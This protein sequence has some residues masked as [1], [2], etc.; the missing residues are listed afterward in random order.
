MKCTRHPAYDSILPLRHA[1]AFSATR[2]DE[3]LRLRARP[4]GAAAAPERSSGSWEDGLGAGGKAA[5]DALPWYWL[6]SSTAAQREPPSLL[7]KHHSQTE[8][9]RESRVDT[10][11]HNH[12]MQRGHCALGEQRYACFNMQ[13]QTNKYS[14]GYMYREASKHSLHSLTLLLH[15]QLWQRERG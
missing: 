3:G 1:Q 8:Q 13:A 5:V 15:G 4:G 2:A 9:A 6:M 14:Y 7:Q 10:H 11:E 12:S